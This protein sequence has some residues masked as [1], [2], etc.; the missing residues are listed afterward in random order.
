ML[1][2][3]MMREDQF[4]ARPGMINLSLPVSLRMQTWF[5]EALVAVLEE[6][7]QPIEEIVKA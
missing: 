1:Y 5:C 4:Y 3:K 7:R 2:L 6:C